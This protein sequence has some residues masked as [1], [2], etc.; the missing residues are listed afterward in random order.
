MESAKES[1]STSEDID[2]LR[3]TDKKEV[4]NITAIQNNFNFVQ[5]VSLQDLAQLAETSPELAQE[6][7][8]IVKKSQ[9]QLHIINTETISLEKKEQ[10]ARLDEIPHL[11][12]YTFRGQLFA[13]IISIVGL[14]TSI[15]FAFLGLKW[16]A[17][18]APITI[19]IGM[20]AI[21]FLDSKSKKTDSLDKND[22]TTIEH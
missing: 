3:N 20:L 16:Q 14:A 9:E 7:I 8:Q 19:P 17:I 21:K 15:L 4:K 22:K 18:I 5:N 6:Y 11:R 13:F 1:M 12:R 10:K 2:I